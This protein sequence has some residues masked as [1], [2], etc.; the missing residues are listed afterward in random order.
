MKKQLISYSQF[1]EYN[2]CPWKFYIERVKKLGKKEI[3]PAISVGFVIHSV[4]KEKLLNPVL[5]AETLMTTIKDTLVKQYPN[6]PEMDARIIEVKTIFD[7]I[8]FDDIFNKYEILNVE[9]DLFQDIND[10]YLFMGILDM[11]LKEKST[12][13][14]II[15]DWK[16]TKNLNS[17]ETYKIKDKQ[18]LAQL[19]FYKYFYQKNAIKE[20]LDNIYIEYWILTPTAPFFI[21]MP[22]AS[23]T[24]VVQNSIEELEYTLKKIYELKIFRKAKFTAAYKC[25]YCQYN[26]DFSL[27]DEEVKQDI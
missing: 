20:E 12:G 17:W 23:E 9:E 11:V 15:A 1:N 4:L 26:N 2:Q 8:P 10:K 14:I 27:C 16:Y 13:K 25:N 6:D 7:N 22:V 24:D 18:V 3:T 5:S 19:Y 21:V